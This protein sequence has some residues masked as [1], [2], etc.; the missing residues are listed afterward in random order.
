MCYKDFL[1]YFIQQ[2]K[3]QI[4]WLV[5]SV[6]IQ[7]YFDLTIYVYRSKMKNISEMHALAT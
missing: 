4:K 5:V 3:R 6:I 7:K 2:Q 1:Q